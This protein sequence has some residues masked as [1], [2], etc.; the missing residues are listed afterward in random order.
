MD[1][2]KDA[3]EIVWHRGEVAGGQLGPQ[4]ARVEER[5]RRRHV[6]E[7]REELVELDGASFPILFLDC[8]A[9]GYA[10]EEALGQLNP[11]FMGVQEV[12][13]VEGLKPQVGELEVA[14]SLKGLAE[15]VEVEAGEFRV[16]EFKFHA[17]LNVSG[18]GRGVEPFHLPL[19]RSVVALG[20][21]RA[22]HVEEGERFP[23]ELIGEQARRGVGVVGLLFHQSAGADYEGG[24]HVGL[25][26]AVKHVFQRFVENTLTIHPFEAL[27]GFLDHHPEAVDV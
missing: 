12:A 10:H 11:R 23:A 24:A 16:E 6:V 17:A 22:A 9:H 14:V 3:V 1:S 21:L 5:R 25:G 19:G 13:V 20:G 4:G 7:G 26:N 18:E 8:E 15:A 27:A 2:A